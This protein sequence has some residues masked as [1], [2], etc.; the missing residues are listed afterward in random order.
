MRQIAL[1]TETTGLDPR[2]GHRVIEIGCVELKDRR[3][4][5]RNFHAYLN[6]KR[7]I[8]AEA[9]AVH[10]LTEEFLAD[11]PLFSEVMDE[12][13][14]FIKGAELIIHNA[15]FDVNFLNHEFKLQRYPIEKIEKHCSIIDT[16]L[17]ARKKHP[18]QKNNLDALC[19]RYYIDNSNRT[20]HGAL[21][22]S[23][24]LAQV[25]LS[26]TGGQSSL[27]DQEPAASVLVSSPIKKDSLAKITALEKKTQEHS[28]ELPVIYATADEREAHEK[29]LETLGRDALWQEEES[30]EQHD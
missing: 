3:F 15:A 1:D 26:M 4:T 30:K 5:E 20:L 17:L 28:I 27:F 21:L 7:E 9:V 11:K 24:L 18:G 6:P 12:F 19:K 25:Y 29:R 22:D 10:G 14:D 2:Q 8:E 13:W 16:L 23:E